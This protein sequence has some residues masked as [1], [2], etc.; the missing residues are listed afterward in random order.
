VTLLRAFAAVAALSLVALPACKSRVAEPSAAD[1]AGWTPTSGTPEAKRR[2]SKED[3]A[4]WAPHGVEATYADWKAAGA[5]CTPEARKALADKI[6]GERVSVDAA[7]LAL[8]SKH[9]GEEYAPADARCYL[10]ARTARALADCRFSPLT[11]PGDTDIAAE[12]ERMRATCAGAPP[13]PRPAP[14]L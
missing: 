3:C 4:K 11:N 12:I 9:L 5:G 8:C 1:E 14:T 6:D 10:A 2:V 13:P 7:A